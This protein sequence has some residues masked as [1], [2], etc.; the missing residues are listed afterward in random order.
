MQGSDTL[1]PV[2]SYEKQWE[3]SRLTMHAA[4]GSGKFRPPVKDP[5][6]VLD[7]LDHHFD[8]VT[9]REEN[10]D[11]PIQNALRALAH[12][13]HPAT[14]AALGGFDPTEGRF[15]RGICQ[16]FQDDKPPQLRKA[17]L[18]F[19]PLISD[20]WFD[21]HPPILDFDGRTTFCINWA[22]VV[23]GIMPK[24][25]DGIKPAP[26][27]GI[28]PTPDELRAILAVLLGMINSPHWRPHIVKEKW[29][30]LEYFPSVPD[31]SQPLKRCI[32]NPELIDA[33]KDV[34]NPQ[35]SFLWLEILWSKYGELKL[36][37]REQLK[38]ATKGV[39][40][41]GRKAD[42]DVYLSAMRLQLKQAQDALTEDDPSPADATA[43]LRK[44]IGNLEQ[45]MASLAALEG[46]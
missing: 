25:D 23:D 28:Q 16:V 27:D 30:L 7:F 44:K 34:V 20:Q 35:A 6:A 24:P 36:Q 38:T 2:F 31:D 17:A 32:D 3:A 39:I 43:A 1:S 40:Q 33:V 8:S 46:D 37:V 42:L 5:Q 19:L 13:C 10:Q 14:I 45:A 41:D 26:D 11:E 9:P 4:Y 22:S 12:T 15:V 18:L 21:A 29:K